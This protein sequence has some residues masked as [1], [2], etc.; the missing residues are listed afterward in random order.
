MSTPKLKLPID[1]NKNVKFFKKGDVIQ[2]AGE[3]FTQGFYVKKGLLRSYTIDEKGKEHIFTFAYEDWIISDLESQEFNRPTEL[4]IDCI[5][6]SEVVVFNSEFLS[7]NSLDNDQLKDQLHLM[8]RRVGVL[9]KRVIMLMSATAKER[10]E[11]FLSK[12][13]DLINR[14]PQKMIASYLGITPQAL[15]TIRRKLVKN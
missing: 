6:D 7:Y 10:Y 15:S 13:P 4:F 5:E 8:A 9:Q 12:Y 2:R 1:L 11:Y 14:V 3:Q